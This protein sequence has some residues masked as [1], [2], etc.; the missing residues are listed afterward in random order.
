MLLK[1][2]YSKLS[3]ALKKAFFIFELHKNQKMAFAGFF[4][5]EKKESLTKGLEKT[6]ESVFIKLSRAIAGKSKVDSDIL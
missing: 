3:S 2:R 4:S 5:R 6:K 1:R